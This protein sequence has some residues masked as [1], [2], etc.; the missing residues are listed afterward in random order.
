MELDRRIG[1]QVRRMRLDVGLS[2]RT[3][4]ETAAIGQSHLSLVERGEREASISVLQAIA[5]ALGADLSVRLYPTTGPPDSRPDAGGDRRGTAAVALADLATG[6][7]GA[8]PLA[9]ERR[10]RLRAAPP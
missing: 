8:R 10:H 4:A 9:G 2:Q 7:G 1:D 5:V 6:P 3:L